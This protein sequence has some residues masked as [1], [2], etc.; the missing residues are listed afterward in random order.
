MV[1]KIN[2]YQMQEP[3]AFS[4]EW[5]TVGAALVRQVTITW[6]RYAMASFKNVLSRVFQASPP[7]YVLNYM[8]PVSGALADVNL[9]PF[10][11]SA[12]VLSEAADGSQVLGPVVLVSRP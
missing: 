9:K 5:V 8:E 11:V 7:A 12:P 2:G 10:S 3:S 6:D 4:T 1:V